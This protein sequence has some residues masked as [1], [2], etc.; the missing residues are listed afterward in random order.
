MPKLLEELDLDA[1]RSE[2]LRRGIAYPNGT[3]LRSA[4]RHELIAA[5]SSQEYVEAFRLGLIGKE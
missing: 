2:C 5:L 4:C 3:P 1:L